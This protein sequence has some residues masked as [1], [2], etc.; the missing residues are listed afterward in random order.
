MFF[1][2]VENSSSSFGTPQ[3][4]VIDFFVNSFRR[5]VRTQIAVEFDFRL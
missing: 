4:F 2:D 1:K 3:R 5:D